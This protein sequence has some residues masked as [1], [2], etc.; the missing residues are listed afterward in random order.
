MDTQQLTS[1][2]ERVDDIPLLLAQMR[3][4]RLV[5]LIEQPFP[6]HGNWQGLSIGQVTAGWLSNILSGG[7]HTCAYIAHTG[8]HYLC[9]LSAVQI[10]QLELERRLE[11]VWGKEPTLSTVARPQPR[12]EID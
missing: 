7:N 3:K 6:A 9:L 10:P 5:E 1:R 8:D 4:I 11:S 2:I 12:E